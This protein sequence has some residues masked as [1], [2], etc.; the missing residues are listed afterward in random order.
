MNC[1]GFGDMHDRWLAKGG[2]RGTDESREGRAPAPT[3]YFHCRACRAS[4]P[5]FHVSDA[6][7]HVPGCGGV[8]EYKKARP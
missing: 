5:P 6:M 3:G 4:V 2:E 1:P 8:V 7:R